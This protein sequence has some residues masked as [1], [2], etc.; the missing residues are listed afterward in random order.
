MSDLV[1]HQ[2]EANTLS[3]TQ[4]SRLCNEQYCW[5]HSL[6]LDSELLSLSYLPLAEALDILADDPKAQISLI[7]TYYK[8]PESLQELITLKQPYLA[9]ILLDQNIGKFT[10]YNNTDYTYFIQALSKA[11]GLKD[12]DLTI[13]TYEEITPSIRDLR[14]IERAILNL[15]AIKLR[16]VLSYLT[17]NIINILIDSTK[18][19]SFSVFTE[20]E[21]FYDIGRELQDLLTISTT[22]TSLELS[23]D[24]IFSPSIYTQLK[25]GLEL[26]QS[27]EELVLHSPAEA[28]N[29]IVL[30]INAAEKLRTLKLLDHSIN[31]EPL[32]AISN[33]ISR[34][35]KLDTL[36]FSYFNTNDETGVL[37]ESLRK[38]HT[39]TSVSIGIYFLEVETSID[40]IQSLPDTITSLDLAE[41]NL[42]A[43]SIQALADRIESTSLNLTYLS[44]ES[45]NSMR[46][47]STTILLKALVK[48]NTITELNLSNVGLSGEVGERTSIDWPE[49]SVFLKQNKSLASLMLD[50]DS[51]DEKELKLLVDALEI[52]TSL[53]ILHLMQI[54]GEENI[55]MVNLIVDII[56]KNKG[57]EYLNL[58]HNIFTQDE[59]GMLIEALNYNTSLIQVDLRHSQSLSEDFVAKYKYDSRILIDKSSREIDY[60]IYGSFLEEDEDRSVDAGYETD[61]TDQT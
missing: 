21:R 26:S 15:E 32:V 23:G 33:L 29:N 43:E 11:T 50:N 40:F 34:S 49:L 24:G 14:S 38:N 58:S 60:S 2:C 37:N 59:L 4:C 16:N 41:G 42:Y 36:A 3:N 46:L 13:S 56:S 57:L 45:Q 61:Y 7:R 47:N 1:Y 8:D 9:V 10:I 55:N 6:N 30:V 5:Q 27:L 52:N 18:I 35:K 22:L 48:S 31:D 20:N 12:L 19:K 25:Y 44:L 54:Y 17:R 53:K 28:D 51:P 39:L